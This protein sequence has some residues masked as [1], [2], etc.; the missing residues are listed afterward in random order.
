MDSRIDHTKTLLDV[1]A[2]L[3]DHIKDQKIEILSLA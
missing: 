3:I 1:I 2:Y